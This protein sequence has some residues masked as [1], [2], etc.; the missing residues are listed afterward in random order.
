[1]LTQSKKMNFLIK[2][3]RFSNTYTGEQKKDHNFNLSPIFNEIIYHL[4]SKNESFLSIK[5]GS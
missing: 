5:S 4:A 1:M 2:P 3:T